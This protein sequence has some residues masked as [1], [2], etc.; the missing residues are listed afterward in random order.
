MALSPGNRSA[1]KN[2][3]RKRPNLEPTSDKYTVHFADW[4]FLAQGQ[5]KWL[6]ALRL[7]KINEKIVP[8]TTSSLIQKYN[9]TRENKGNSGRLF[10]PTFFLS[11]CHR[12]F[13][14]VDSLKGVCWAPKACPNIISLFFFGTSCCS[15]DLPVVCVNYRHSLFFFSANNRICESRHRITKP[16]ESALYFSNFSAR[17]FFWQWNYI[18]KALSFS[19]DTVVTVKVAPGVYVIN[20]SLVVSSTLQDLTLQSNDTTQLPSL[21]CANT[22]VK[23]F[24]TNLAALTHLTINSL[25]VLRLLMYINCRSKTA[26][27][28]PCP[29]RYKLR[30]AYSTVMF[31][32][33][34]MAVRWITGAGRLQLTIPYSR[35]M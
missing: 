24:S 20:S 10:I 19:G 15:Y 8:K 18:G 23:L 7:I 6:F 34:Q 14:L 26:R 30:T 31:H 32:Q 25:K 16:N 1:G 5:Q 21:Q 11:S 22:G 27:R 3:R 13:F 35:T 33:P 9:S 28:M 17:Y 12:K 2:Y 29:L 4:P